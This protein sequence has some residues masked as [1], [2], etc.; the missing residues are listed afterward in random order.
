MF[1]DVRKQIMDKNKD[2][3]RRFCI[4]LKDNNAYYPFI[5]N[6]NFDSNYIKQRINRYSYAIIS[7][8]FTWANTLESHDF[9]QKIDNKWRTY[10]NEQNKHNQE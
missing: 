2:N 10:V 6:C 3:L 9:W 7:C 4:F 1:Y 8:S 5:K